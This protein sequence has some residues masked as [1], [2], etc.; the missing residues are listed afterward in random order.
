MRSIFEAGFGRRMIA[1]IMDAVVFAA[2]YLFMMF[3]FLN[4]KKEPY[5]LGEKLNLNRYDIIRII[6]KELGIDYKK[7]NI[8]YEINHKYYLN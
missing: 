7:K 4:G 1:M 3:G 5:L 6:D 2:Q 8:L